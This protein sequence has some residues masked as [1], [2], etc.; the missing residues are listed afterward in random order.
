MARHV[1]FYR[2]RKMPDVNTSGPSRAEQNCSDEEAQTYYSGHPKELPND[3]EKLPQ[4]RPVTSKKLGDCSRP[5]QTDFGWPAPPSCMPKEVQIGSL[6]DA[7]TTQ[8]QDFIP[9]AKKH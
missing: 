6:T 7:K 5:K 8:K 1:E 9:C 2:K 3:T 4:R